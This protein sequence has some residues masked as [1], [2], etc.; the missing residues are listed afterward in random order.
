MG[1]CGFVLVIVGVYAYVY[2]CKGGL[3]M[4]VRSVDLFRFEI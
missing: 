4:V 1:E 3:G 2:A